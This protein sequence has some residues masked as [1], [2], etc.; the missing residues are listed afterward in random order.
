VHHLGVVLSGKDVSGA[1]HVCGQ[2]IYLVE[3]PVDHLAAKER[4][5]KVTKHEIISLYFPEFGKFQI[6]TTDPKPIAF[7]PVNDVA[8]NKPAGAENES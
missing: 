1:A 8:A 2:L 6:D 3:F 5:S 7:Q 4:I